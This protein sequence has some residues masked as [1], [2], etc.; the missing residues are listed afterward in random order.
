MLH[1]EWAEGAPDRI[2]QA[3]CMTCPEQSGRVDSNSDPVARWALL[4]PENEGLARSQFF[5]T[6][7]RHWRVDPA[8]VVDRPSGQDHEYAPH[9]PRIEDAP[10]K[11][12]PI[13][14][15]HERWSRATK[16]GLAYAGRFAGPFVLA[17]FVIGA[18][19]CGFLVGSG[20]GAG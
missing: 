10:T 19:L 9:L 18:A 7:E 4:H 11:E 5:V 15:L 12:T 2:Y 17:C 8:S 3:E 6:V 14:R 13:G 20:A 1:A 16:R